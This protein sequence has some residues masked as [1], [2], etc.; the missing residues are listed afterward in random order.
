M[1][2][3]MNNL[4]QILWEDHKYNQ[5]KEPFLDI[6]ICGELTFEQEFC[7]IE[8]LENTSKEAKTNIIACN[9]EFIRKH[10]DRNGDTLYLGTNCYQKTAKKNTLVNTITNLNEIVQIP[11][12]SNQIWFISSTVRIMN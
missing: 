3:L 4:E 12:D 11:Q 1:K 5:E 2:N 9:T 10:T 7:L 6:I 8:L